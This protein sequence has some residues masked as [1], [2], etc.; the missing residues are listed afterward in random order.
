MDDDRSTDTHP[1]KRDMGLRLL[2]ALATLGMVAVVLPFYGAVLWAAI[3]G[4][5][6]GPVQRAVQQRLGG[7]RNLAAALTLLGVALVVVL[8]LLA[9]AVS[10]AVQLAQA[11]QSGQIDVPGMLQGAFNALPDPAA[12]LLAHFGIGDVNDLRA[13]IEASA[14]RAAQ[15]FAGHML[16]LGQSTLEF[17][18]QL[19]VSLYVAFFMLRDGDKL[20]GQVWAAL[21]LRDGDKR[22]LR[23]RVS[24]VVRATVKGNLVVALVQGALGGI[25]LA[26]LG[27]PGALLAGALMAVVSLLPA[28]GAALVWGPIAI[29]LLATGALWQGIALAVFGTV[30]I[31]LI[32]NLLRPVLVGR[33][34]RLPDWLVLV[35]T[36]GGIALIGLNGFVLGPLVGTLF[37]AG[38]GIYAA[39]RQAEAGGAPT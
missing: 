31:G 5:V 26:V 12:S 37:L 17:V 33:D 23:E 14:G 8:P 16:T 29:Y 38:W 22:E 32:D 7:R 11:V 9:L 20:S 30:V 24:A 15:F 27:I 1:R 3:L 6:F 21:P 19:F 10:L 18:V 25:A 2:V 28:V 36:I 4:L 39:R 34:T 13:R 35:T